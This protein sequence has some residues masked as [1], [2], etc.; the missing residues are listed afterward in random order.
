MLIK[1]KRLLQP[2]TILLTLILTVS[3]G[4]FLY[5]I[6]YKSFWEDEFYSLRD[7]LSIDFIN[8]RMWDEDRGF[9]GP[10]GIRIARPFYYIILRLWLLFGISDTWMRT[11]SVVFALGCIYLVYEL[12]K[13]FFHQYIGVL[14]ATFLMLSPAFIG[15][16]QEA[17]MYTLG[18]FLG[19]LGSL[20]L[21]K[22][23]QNPRPQLQSIWLLS[24][25]AMVLSI[26]ITIVLFISEILFLN[27]RQNLKLSPQLKALFG[28]SITLSFLT[29][30]LAIYEE[31]SKLLS[32]DSMSVTPIDWLTRIAEYLVAIDG[33][34]ASQ[35]ALILLC[36]IFIFSCFWLASKHATQEPILLLL[37]WMLIPSIVISLASLKISSVFSARYS[38]FLLPFACIVIAYGLFALSKVSHG[39][40][41]WS[42]TAILSCFVAVYLTA[43]F[44]SLRTYYA[45]SGTQDWRQAVEL[46]EQQA[47]LCDGL[48]HYRSA[49]DQFAISLYSR[50]LKFDHVHNIT[51][52]SDLY[53]VVPKQLS[54]GSGQASCNLWLLI[55][56]DKISSIDDDLLGE[57][58][59]ASQP[60][61]QVQTW[62]FEGV[63]VYRFSSEQ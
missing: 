34:T 3:C 9:S 54:Q 17:R 42:S 30:L 7:A 4:L 36:G 11:L 5:R 47:Q 63:N 45:S 13:I 18:T 29:L 37:V 32:S 26:P 41:R 44:N 22:N 6:S 31:R 55:M 49:P 62:K 14:S 59:G 12:G 52:K 57:R 21:L 43:S 58:S 39:R 1:P 8:G 33:S 51:S 15:H 50:N 28:V 38:A 56:N 27:F 23:L 53:E 35:A 25:L 48:I 16:A 19:L 10:F 61:F 2:D 40:M 46:I 24:R 20:V 60:R